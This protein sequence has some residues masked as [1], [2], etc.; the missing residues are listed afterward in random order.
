M[1]SHPS[2]KLCFNTEYFQRVLEKVGKQSTRD[3]VGITRQKDLPIFVQPIDMQNKYV[4]I[5]KKLRIAKAK[6]KE[7]MNAD[8]SLFESLSQQ[9][10]NGEL[11]KQNKA[12]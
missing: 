11:S 10:F 6:L 5:Y 3:Y 4:K 8:R 9:A 2:D 12:A 7:A 1:D